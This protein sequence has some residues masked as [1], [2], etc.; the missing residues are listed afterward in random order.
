MAVAEVVVDIKH[1]AVDRVF[2]YEVPGALVDV[3]VPGVR[4]MVPFGPRSLAGFVL[5]IKASSD[6]EGKLRKISKVMDVVPVLNEELLALGVELARETGA[7]M[8]SCFD[9]MIPAA[10]KLKYRKMFVRIWG[11]EVCSQLMNL[12]GQSETV[13]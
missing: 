3:I 13:D 4:V 9:A 12:F 2:D 5:R 6:F 1:K 10:M 8:I 11:T 7:T